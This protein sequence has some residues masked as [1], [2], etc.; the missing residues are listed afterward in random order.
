VPGLLYDSRVAAA[1]QIIRKSSFKAVRW[2]NGGGTTHEAWRVPPAGDPFLFRVSVAHIDSSGPFSDFAG[3]T[4]HMVLLQGAGLTLVF[5]NGERRLLQRVG[6][7][8]EFDGAMPIRCELLDGPCIDLNFMKHE[9]ARAEAR[10]VMLGPSL[11]LQASPSTLIFGIGGPVSLDADGERATLEP[12]DLAVVSKCAV[13]LSSIE[14]GDLSAPSAVFF[15]T[16][17]HQN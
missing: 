13:R 10:V 3:Y 2:K 9:S 14:S 16:I 1:L 15:A 5:G 11:L 7:S 6:E 4:R 8:V 17:T 12:W